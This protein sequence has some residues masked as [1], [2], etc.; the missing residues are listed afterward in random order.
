MGLRDAGTGTPSL[1]THC[2][3]SSTANQHDAI[4]RS[5]SAVVDYERMFWHPLADT[6]PINEN[7]GKLLPVVTIVTDNG[8]TFRSLNFELSVYHLSP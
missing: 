1:S 8:G 5:N 2:L 6:C 7:T 3:T 4:A